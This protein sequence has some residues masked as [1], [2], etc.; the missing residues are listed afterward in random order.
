MKRTKITRATLGELEKTLQAFTVVEQNSFIGGGKGDTMNEAYSWNEY[1]NI[2]Q[3]WSKGWVKIS[4]DHYAYYTQPYSSDDP[5]TEY[6]DTYYYETLNDYYYNNP[7]TETTQ[8]NCVK[9]GVNRFA[10]GENS[11][12]SLFQIWAYDKNNNIID[13]MTGYFLERKSDYDKCTTAGSKTAIKPG[14]YGISPHNSN[15]FPNTYKLGD[16]PGRNGILIHTGNNYSDSTG[17]L[18]IGSDYSYN[19]IDYT[20]SGSNDKMNE[21]RDFINHYG[22]GHAKIDISY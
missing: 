22:N 6:Y 8:N 18:L 5:N 4:D 14:Q 13:T 17:C 9:I 11:T 19:G 21:F 7:N 2:G 20:I 16:V 12:L 15:R 3:Q 1:V 10:Y